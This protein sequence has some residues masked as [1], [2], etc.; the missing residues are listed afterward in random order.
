MRGPLTPRRSA[1]NRQSD[2]SPRGTLFKVLP[3]TLCTNEVAVLPPVLACK[4][5]IS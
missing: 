2:S 1:V 5:V 4:N 3:D